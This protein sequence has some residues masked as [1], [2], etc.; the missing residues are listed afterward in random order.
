MASVTDAGEWLSSNPHFTS[1]AQSGTSDVLW[2]EGKPGSGKSTLMKKIW[3]KLKLEEDAIHAPTESVDETMS[4]TRQPQ[5][6]ET[7]RSTICLRFFYSSRGGTKERDHRSML[8]SLLYQILTQNTYLF[9]LV[10][11][12]YL[13]VKSRTP[14][15]TKPNWT[16]EDL[17]LALRSLQD[18]GFPIKIIILIDGFDES[19]LKFRDDALSVLTGLVSRRSF[20][21]V[22]VLI[23]S[24]PGNDLQPILGRFHHII[25][26]EENAG[27]IRILVDAKIEKVRRMC[28]SLGNS[29]KPQ[30]QIISGR[31]DSPDIF[32]R[33]K[34]YIIEASWGVILWVTLVLDDMER[35]VRR[36]GYSQEDLER[37]V[38]G[39][40]RELGG[41]DGFYRRIL[42]S[43]MERFSWEGGREQDIERG[44]RIFSWAAF[45]KRPITTVELND[46]LAIPADLANPSCHNINKFRLQDL[47]RGIVSYCGGLVEVSVSCL[48]VGL[49][50]TE[51]MAASRR[52]R[53]PPY[54]PAHASHSKG[55]SSRSDAVGDAIRPR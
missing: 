11:R 40:P 2:I 19:D 47:A 35:C 53:H 42:D 39:L 28:E 15:E 17:K 6:L 27:D 34:H 5:R 8:Q 30:D 54:C 3:N 45:P 20:C 46:A 7:D 12:S 24:R 31:I 23:S 51:Q 38:C 50:I 52:F 22:K 33:I 21:T 37:R 10:R 29:T 9:P 55:I 26:Q 48:L 4:G 43:L 41:P 14:S 44:R 18:V 32:A 13:E 1:W 36:G 16:Y 49:I 25:L